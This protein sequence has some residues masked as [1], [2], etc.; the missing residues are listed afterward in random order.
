MQNTKLYGNIY[1]AHCSLY[2]ENYP[3]GSKRK[4]VI[5]Y[6]LLVNSKK[7]RSLIR[8]TKLDIANIEYICIYTLYIHIYC[9]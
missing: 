1:V 2:Q 6:I 4:H 5:A 8:N 7:I 9:I 3:L